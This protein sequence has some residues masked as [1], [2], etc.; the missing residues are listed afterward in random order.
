MEDFVN[1][2]NSGWE[3]LTTVTGKFLSWFTK[4]FVDAYRYLRDNVG[5]FFADIIAGAGA[6]AVWV[7]K[8]ADAI[9]NAWRAP[10]ITSMIDE[11]KFG[12]KNA[13]DAWAQ[14]FTE[15][16]DKSYA[17]V[18]RFSADAY[19]VSTRYAG[20]FRDATVETLEEWKRVLSTQIG[21]D[22]QAVLDAITVKINKMSE[23]KIDLLPRDDA[24]ELQKR[25][26][27]LA[28][29]LKN[30]ISPAADEAAKT[31]QDMLDALDMEIEIVGLVNKGYE[32]SADII[33]F[34]YAAMKKFNGEV[35]RV[36]EAVDD[37]M[38]KLEE[39]GDKQQFS[40]LTDWMREN[41]YDNLWKNLSEDA[42]QGLDDLSSTITDF[43]TG[44]E[45][46][47]RQFCAS[48]LKEFLNTLV[49][50]QMQQIATTLIT[51]F[52]QAGAGAASG[53][54]K[55][56]GATDIT[57][58][59]PSGGVYAA[60]GAA[61]DRGRIV[62]MSMGGIV[63]TPTVV[64]MAGGDRAYIAEREPEAVAPLVKT[65]S[66]RLGIRMEGDSKPTVIN[67]FKIVNVMTREEQ[68]AAMQSEEGEQ[69]FT[70]YLHRAGVI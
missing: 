61:F 63:P 8:I 11:I 6:A 31:M 5:K 43:I 2:I 4:A 35:I 18:K 29:S 60:M 9:K 70:N 69:I 22:A 47:W 33:A 23:S 17:D 13:G 40:A 32:R 51:S 45:V 19:D 21:A 16:W 28:D 36:N 38:A 26:N 20:A 50:M 55:A 49:R 1:V 12:A 59:T 42:A 10:D 57:T 39:L 46:D 56:T 14:A 37:Y 41:D 34:K 27:A 65:R 25:F 15:T 67:R 3:W 53:G 54:G 7:G 30:D 68:L 58:A 44:T 24:D 66:G 62:A 64:P 48:I 52:A